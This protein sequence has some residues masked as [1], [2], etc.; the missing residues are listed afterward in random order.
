MLAEYR[1][2][3]QE[4]EITLI[5]KKSKFIARIKP[6]QTREEAEAFLEEVRKGALERHPQCAGLYH[7][8]EPRDPEIQ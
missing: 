6:V 4:A 1:T 8:H 2:V 7:R 3:A 5:E